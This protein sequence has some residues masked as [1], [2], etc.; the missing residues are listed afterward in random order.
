MKSNVISKFKPI[1]DKALIDKLSIESEY[2][3]SVIDAMNYSVS[4]GGKRIRPCLTL[5]FARICGGNQQAAINMACAV[6]MIHTYSL[7]HDDLPCMD[8]DDL[9]R[10]KP[11]CHIKFGEATAL[12]A[13]DGLLTY[14]FS[15]AAA[16]KNIKPEYVSDCVYIL[17]ECAGI[18]GMIGGQVIDLESEG[19][20]IPYSVLET[21]CQLK[22]S[23]LLEAACKLGC[24]VSGADE[25]LI[26]AAS[27]YAKYLGL[28]FQ[29]VDDI[30]DI[31]GDTEK[32]GKPT[33]SDSENNKSTFV[34]LLGLEKAKLLAEEYTEKAI[35]SLE[36]FGD[37][38]EQLI[39][40]AKDLCYRDY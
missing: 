14:A 26:S 3:S 29:I 39:L 20:D 18:N 38:A 1:I 8:N 40:L 9:R 10:G 37:S 16:T 25:G 11:S 13:G 28:A 32:L 15:T 6:E 27:N 35:A 30:L 21:L 4:I 23:R 12:L 17:S 22:T 7:I 24:V 19:K 34:S 5:E 31:V 33:G 36:V 2:Y